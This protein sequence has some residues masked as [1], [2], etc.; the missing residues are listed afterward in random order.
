MVIL[1]NRFLPEEPLRGAQRYAMFKVQ[2]VIDCHGLPKKLPGIYRGGGLDNGEFLKWFS[3][4]YF[5]SEGVNELWVND[6]SLAVKK[7]K[8]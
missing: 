2:V 6:C 3:L 7:L 4:N 5:L 1:N 8:K